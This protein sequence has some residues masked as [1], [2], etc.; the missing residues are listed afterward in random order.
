M[1]TLNTPVE[2]LLF[3]VSLAIGYLIG[4]INPGYFFGRIV[5][6]VDLREVGTKN[7]G[8]SN[9]YKVLGFKYALITGIFDIFKAVIAITICLWWLD[10]F[11]AQF[12][13][14]ATIIGHIFPF[15]LNFRGGEGV[16]AAIGMWLFYVYTYTSMNL[17]FLFMLFFF[18]ILAAIFSY[19]THTFNLIP[20]SSFSLMIFFVYVHYPES[21]FTFNIWFTLIVLHII[22]FT[23]IDFFK[24][25]EFKIE[26][27]SIK[28]HRW[29]I[30]LRFGTLLFVIL[31]GFYDLIV[32]L[33]CVSIFLVLFLV[34]DFYRLAKKEPKEDQASKLDSL[35]RSKEF[36][37]FSSITVYLVAYFI[38]ILIFPKN[39]A[40]SAIV[41]LIFGDVFG[42]IFGLKYGKHH[43]LGKSLEGSLAY[44]GVMIMCGYFLHELLGISP[45]ILILG[46]L[47]AP[48]TELFTLKMNDNFTVPIICGTVMLLPSLLAL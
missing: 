36:K 8:T 18:I 33:I 42:K 26:D 39:I 32:P 48:I 9:T 37:K 12:S 23:L 13:G 45:I 21:L 14:I 38:T 43:M 44:L 19:V 25:T 11:W 10:P 30:L 31:Y 35:Y 34:L 40:I 28:G 29:R 27:E 1:Y 3:I 41:F 15:Y 47:A 46:C 20:A 24:Q 7:A 6:K 2:I 4:S 16:A 17:I 22:I 5:K